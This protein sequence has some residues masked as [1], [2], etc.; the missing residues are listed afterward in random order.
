MGRNAKIKVHSG[1]STAVEFFSTPAGFNSAVIT[2][3]FRYAKIL[4]AQ[5]KDIKSG[6]DS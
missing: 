1:W 6:S 4:K 2:N 5:K 3:R